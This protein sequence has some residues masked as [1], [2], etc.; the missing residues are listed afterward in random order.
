MRFIC[1]FLLCVLTYSC[2]NNKAKSPK[3]INF[4]PDNTSVILK[5]ANLEG[6]KSSLN[7]SDFLQKIS[8]VNSY[9][10]IKN[11]LVP[12]TRLNS[13]NDILIC[14]S[15]NSKDSLDCSLIT[16]Y[17]KELLRTD[18]LSNYTEE[19]LTLKNKTI[20]KSTINNSHFYSTIIDS[21]F[22]VSSSKN[23]IEN[24]FSNIVSDTELEKIYNTTNNDKTLSVILKPNN[25]FLKSFFIEDSLSLKSFTNYIVTDVDISQNNIFIN[26]IT[27]ATD[28][29]KSLINIFKNTIPQENQVQNI[30][31]SNS[32]G[33]MSFTSNDFKTIE[34]NL[35][36]Y[37]SQDSI[38]I[39]SPLFN[40]ITEIGVIYEDKNRAIVLN[41]ID[42]IA[43]KDALAGEQNVID[44]YREIKIYDYSQPSLFSKTFYPLISF[45]K[46]NK[47]CL[48]DNFFVFANTIE[49]LQNI[50]AS[51]QN[52][53]T[54]DNKTYFEDIKE[55][56]NDASSLML[57]TDYKT[58][59]SILN[60]NSQED[61]NYKL[62]G[63][64]ASA[65]QFIYDTNFAHVNGIIKK[66][67][68][69]VSQN[70]V[71]EILNIKLDTDLLNG[72]QLVTNHITK[73]KEIVVQD[74]NNNLYLISNEGK[75]IWKK[76]VEGA[77]IGAIKQID[78]YK[79]GRLQ[80]AFTTPNNIYIID[81]KGNN[82]SPFPKQFNSEIT[83][84]LA[85]FDYDKN[86]KYRLLVTQGKNVLMFDTKGAVVTGFKFKSADNNIIC[87]PKHFRIGSKDYIS[88]KTKNKL[89]ILDRVGKTRVKPKTSNTYSNQPIFLYNNTF[90]TTTLNG[91][92]VSVDSK[93]NV[94][95]KNLNLSKKHNI[96][97]T[98]KTLIA[99][100]ENKLSI[101]SKTIEL[102]YGNYSNT[103]LF[104][105]NNKIYVSI[106]D[107]QSHKI[108]LYDSQAKSLKNNFPVFGNSAIDLDNI[109]KDKN[110]EFVTKGENNSI[111]I[112]QIN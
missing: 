89:Y 37:N 96:T 104:Y 72:P 14:F 69:K 64:T 56:L 66:N 81:R 91:S 88:F 110:I 3:L 47:Y 25:T 9:S 10:S 15:K 46:A 98:N 41:S 1:F 102:D 111:I 67:K 5:T 62:K 109:D 108:Y 48:I 30:T 50:I 36:K 63:Y 12:F 38:T 32:D 61:Y 44:T 73:E 106:T 58:L 39:T 16:K 70:S 13:K 76:Q 103:Q 40:D 59:N 85:V 65:I 94:S 92:L 43:T 90:T 42:L 82:V 19:T 17:H 95:T 54:L 100:S 105:I 31:P 27:K 112:Y 24:S 34:T 33:F 4:I 52:K 79:N 93:G 83:Q 20:T 22:I 23:V 71:S 8:E 51:Y 55:N 53:T 11:K 77:V 80:L 84:P 107:L 49:L 7:N 18:S 99:Q 74:V 21:I 68:T 45:D 6:L 86:K 87:Q 101:K 2:S 78:I 28:S 57:I 26:G 29:T 35:I 60:K 75:I 97:A